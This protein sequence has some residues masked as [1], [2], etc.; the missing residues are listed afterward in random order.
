MTATAD[1][2]DS[3]DVLALVQAVEGLQ[4]TVERQ[5]ERIDELKN[6]LTEYKDFAGSEFADVRGRISDAEDR[7]VETRSEDVTS[8]IE[9]DKTGQQNTQTPLEQICALPEHIADR[10]L[11]VNQKRARFI[12]TDV[13]DY[14]EKAPAGL[15]I[16]S[17]AIKR[18][19]STAKEG[20]CPH[21]QTGARVMNFL[22]DLEKVDAEL[23]KRR[24]KKLVIVDPKAADCYHSCCDFR[25]TRTE[26]YGSGPEST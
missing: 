25:R 26:T 7:Q 24:G 19:H 16:D 3:I 6:E 4:E 11:T 17:R 18:S 5:A 20:T 10:E 15:V 14:A 13:C 23:K 21:T 8:G 2:T 9:D 12:A 1:A 22:D